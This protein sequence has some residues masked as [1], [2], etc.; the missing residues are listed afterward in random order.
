MYRTFLLLSLVILCKGSNAQTPPSD[1]LNERFSPVVTFRTDKHQ[2]LVIDIHDQG[3]RIRQDIVDPMDL[4]PE[5]I[6]YSTDEGGLVLK[7]LP[8]RAQCITKE[9]FKLDVVRLTSRV[10]IPRPADD[11]DGS[12]ATVLLREWV[13]AAQNGNDQAANG[14]PSKPL[15]MNGR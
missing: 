6:A 4:D 15:R 10:T 11:P 12:A 5:A 2:R 13:E 8:D 7:C 3:E 14:T 9:I 1:R